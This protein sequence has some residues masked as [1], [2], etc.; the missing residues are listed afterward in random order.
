MSAPQG[1]ETVFGA[2]RAVFCENDFWAV[3]NAG[4]QAGWDR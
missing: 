2:V 1:V 3:W 4:E